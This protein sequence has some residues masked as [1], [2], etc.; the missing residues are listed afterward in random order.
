MKDPDGF[1]MI[2]RAVL[3]IYL[4]GDVYDVFIKASSISICSFEVALNAMCFDHV[5]GMLGETPR[6]NSFHF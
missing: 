4:Y 2:F 6:R 5:P 3:D 1:Q